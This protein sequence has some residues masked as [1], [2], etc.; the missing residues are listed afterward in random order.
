DVRP[1]RGEVSGRAAAKLVLRRLRDGEPGRA[2]EEGL[3]LLQRLAVGFLG[4]GLEATAPIE[5]ARARRDE[6]LVETRRAGAVER[7]PAEGDD[8]RQR[9]LIVLDHRD[10]REVGRR[11]SLGDE[12]AEDALHERMVEVQMNEIRRHLLGRIEHD[13]KGLLVSPLPVVLVPL[14]RWTQRVEGALPARG[15]A[16]QTVGRAV[17]N[18]RPGAGEL[19]PDVD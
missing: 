16:W 5:P 10:P 3:E 12:A 2:G 4:E 6:L 17:S 19:E 18:E 15:H 1:E 11:V 8:A 9:I 7:Q 13:G 14:A